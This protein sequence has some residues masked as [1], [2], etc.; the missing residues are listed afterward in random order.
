MQ[1]ILY[2]FAIFTL[3]LAFAFR[4]STEK[5]QKI[6]RNQEIK[7]S[8]TVKKEPNIAGGQQVLELGD[9]KVY[10]D[11]YPRY[12]VGDQIAVEGKVDSEGRIFRPQIEVVGRKKTLAGFF[13]NLRLKIS[14]NIASYLPSREATIVSGTV[15]GVDTI[16]RD[17]RDQLV[18]TGTI[19]VVVVSG[20]NLMIV[21]G[22]FLALGR[23]FGRRRSLVLATAAVF[24][25]AFLTGFEPPVVR[26]SLMVLAST[27]AIF[28][29]RQTFPIW[30]LILAASVILFFWPQALF[31]VSF[32]LTFAATL[33]IMT[34]G[35]YLTKIFN[36]KF[37]IL[38]LFA[39][40]AAIATSAYLF[41]APIILFYFGRI[42]PLAPFANIL[43]AEA[44]FPIMILGFLVSI[45]SLIFSPFAQVISYIAYVPAYYFVK[46]VEVFAKIPI[47]QVSFGKGNMAVVAGFYLLLLVLMFVWMRRSRI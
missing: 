41:T 31:E 42:S 3:G 5:I 4:L 33:G 6:P 25:Y 34:L 13:S 37:L 46:V 8:A 32:Q 22:V 7:L 20:Q 24:T 38:N 26:A 40:N 21:A 19:H 39:D 17:F 44:V 35:R 9:S 1:R 16:E 14:Q 10:V 45:V 12:K 28:L 29:G 47:G 11:L 2:V 36:F 15:L 23:Y 27:L 43:I 30:Q 18:K